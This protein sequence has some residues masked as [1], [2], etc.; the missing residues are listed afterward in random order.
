MCG[1]PRD[2]GRRVHVPGPAHVSEGVGLD[3][4][5]PPRSVQ[6]EGGDSHR[7]STSVVTS[8]IR[9]RGVAD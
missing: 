2:I 3:T 8:G 6:G 1:E 5:Y 9:P 7:V 4:G